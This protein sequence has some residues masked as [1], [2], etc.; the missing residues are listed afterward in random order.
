ME[1][2][3][4]NECQEG[5][6]DT[7]RYITAL[8]LIHKL[9]DDAGV[10]YSSSVQ[11]CI[12]GLG[13]RENQLENNEF[14]SEVYLKVLRPLEQHLKDFCGKSLEEI[15]KRQCVYQAHSLFPPPP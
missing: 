5:D 3:H 15:F 11:R 14:K 2:F 1:S 4:A 9:N 6:P 12:T 13:H 8:E 7:T 10:N